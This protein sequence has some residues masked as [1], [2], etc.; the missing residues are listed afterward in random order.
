MDGWWI[1]DEWVNNEQWMTWMDGW[2]C[3]CVQCRARHCN[4]RQG[5]FASLLATGLGTSHAPLWTCFF[6]QKEHSQKHSY[7]YKWGVERR[8]V[9]E[10]DV[11][12]R[13][14][15]VL[16]LRA[17]EITVFGGKKKIWRMWL[18]WGCWDE[19][20]GYLCLVTQSCPTLCDPLD[21]SPPGYSVH[22]IFHA[23]I[24]EWVAIFLL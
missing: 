11:F 5:F 15:H 2:T 24:Q 14:P 8:Q 23:R 17:C 1:M 20:M 16:I 10:A 3:E 9:W 13:C 19:I 6:T 21:C 12:Q 18:R 7:K 22:G 4:R